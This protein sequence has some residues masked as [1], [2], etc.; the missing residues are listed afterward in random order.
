M[1]NPLKIILLKVEMRVVLMENDGSICCG[2][3]NDLDVV[4]EF[5]GV[6]VLS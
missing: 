3:M 2:K 1:R 4:S 5:I 6:G